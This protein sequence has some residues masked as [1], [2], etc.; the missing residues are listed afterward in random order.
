MSLLLDCS[1]QG[2]HG[3]PELAA[4]RINAEQGWHAAGCTCVILYPMPTLSTAQRSVTRVQA[5]QAGSH[6]IH[7]PESCY[8]CSARPN[9]DRDS[10]HMQAAQAGPHMAQPGLLQTSMDRRAGLGLSILHPCHLQRNPPL[11]SP[12]QQPPSAAPNSDSRLRGWGSRG[13]AAH[14]SLRGAV[15]PAVVGS[16]QAVHGLRDARPARPVWG[17]CTR[18]RAKSVE[19]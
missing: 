14:N 5:T 15:A 4:Q 17:L 16:G 13:P 8:V 9:P 18:P 3:P 2:S 7:W 6:V 12:P 1:S 19:C 10:A 11:S